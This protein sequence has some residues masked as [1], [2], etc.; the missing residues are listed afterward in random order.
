MIGNITSLRFHGPG[1]LVQLAL[2]LAACALGAAR[3]AHAQAVTA[4]SGDPAA[5]ARIRAQFAETQREAP[6]YRRT[7]RELQGYSLEGGRVEGFYRGEELRM[8]RASHFGEGGQATEEYYFAGERLVFV[9]IVDE[10]YDQPIPMDTRVAL[11]SEHRYYFDGGRLIRQIH[12]PPDSFD[13]EDPH[14]LLEWAERFSAC[15]AATGAEPPECT[16]PAN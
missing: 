16:A 14:T 13:E 5:I 9:F 1:R 8:L 7:T 6:T 2:V 3:P 11:R 10:E 12:T 15:A 4:T